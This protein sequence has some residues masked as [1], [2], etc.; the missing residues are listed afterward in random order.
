MIYSTNWEDVEARTSTEEEFDWRSE[1]AWFMANPS[2]GEIIKLEDFRQ[3]CLEAQDS[4]E[5]E[6]HL[7]VTGSIFGHGQRQDGL[8]L[9][10]GRLVVVSLIL[11]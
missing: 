4:P 9:R 8:A 5:I 1:K 2:L 11:I 3:E 10:S 7:S 6:T